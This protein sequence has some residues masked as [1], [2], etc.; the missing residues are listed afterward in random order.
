[1]KKGPKIFACGANLPHRKLRLH[2]CWTPPTRVLAES[3]NKSNNTG[4]TLR[5]R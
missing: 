4:N 5:Y 1:L 2:D 3:R